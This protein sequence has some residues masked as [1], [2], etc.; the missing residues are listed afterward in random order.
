MTAC[1]DKYKNKMQPLMINFKEIIPYDR[2]K[3]RNICRIFGEQH[4]FSYFQ[5]PSALDKA[6]GIYQ[7][8]MLNVHHRTL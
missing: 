4:F 8:A 2:G 5:K 6:A 3:D 7:L 1:S